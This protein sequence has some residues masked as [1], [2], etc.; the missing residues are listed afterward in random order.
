MTTT[1]QSWIDVRMLESE[2]SVDTQY[3]SE[4]FSKGIW[5]AFQGIVIIHRRND[6]YQNVDAGLRQFLFGTESL[7]IGKDGRYLVKAGFG[8]KLSSELSDIHQMMTH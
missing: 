6:Q 8:F 7:H 3:R 5:I 2:Q 1:G 4:G